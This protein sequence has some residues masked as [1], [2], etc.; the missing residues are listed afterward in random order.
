MIRVDE[1]SFDDVGRCVALKGKV[2]NGCSLVGVD[3]EGSADDVCTSCP[4][5]SFF[6]NVTHVSTYKTG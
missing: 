3:A 6:S 4:Q 1:I 2:I 5:H